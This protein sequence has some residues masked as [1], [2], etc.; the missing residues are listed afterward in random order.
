VRPYK[1]NQSLGKR[2]QKLTL[3]EFRPFILAVLIVMLIATAVLSD[4]QES[5][6]PVRFSTKPV[7][8]AEFEDKRFSSVDQITEA[9]EYLYI[10]PNNGDGFIQ[11]YDLGGNYLHSLF[12]LER[13]NGLFQTASVGDTFYVEDQNHNVFVFCEGQFREYVKRDEAAK[14]FSTIPFV[15]KG[16]AQGY[17]IRKCDLWRVR[18][19]E[20]VLV[21]PDLLHFNRASNVICLTALLGLGFFY[22]AASWFKRR[23]TNQ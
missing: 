22:L 1:K 15:W 6:E 5:R 12:F 14:R 10:V 9:G 2:S 21:I 11:V 23:R 7:S 18:D 4:K 17:E 3:G 16:F 13:K 8:S 19:G 20:A